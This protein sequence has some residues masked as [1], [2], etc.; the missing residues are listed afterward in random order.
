MVTQTRQAPQ[1]NNISVARY[2]LSDIIRE[3]V[4]YHPSVARSY[5]SY[6]RARSLAKAASGQWQPQV[7]LFGSH[8]FKNDFSLPANESNP[9]NETKNSYGLRV[10]QNLNYQNLKLTQKGARSE[11]EASKERLF[12]SQDQIGVE[13]ALSYVQIFRFYN[14][15][16]IGV[17]YLNLL[18]RI[19]GKVKARTKSGLTNALETKKVA[20]IE[21]RVIA[22]NEFNRRQYEIAQIF[23][24]NISGIENLNI[25]AL[26]DFNFRIPSLALSEE[27]LVEKAISTN[28]GLTAA[29]KDIEIAE[30]E[31][32]KEKLSRY[33]T[34]DLDADLTY[35]D[36][37]DASREGTFR[38]GSV[39]INMN[40]DIWT[41]RTKANKIAS[42]RWELEEDI[43]QYEVIK[44]QVINQVQ[45]SYTGFNVAISEYKHAEEARKKAIELLRLQEQDFS[46][47]STT[48]LLDLINTTQDWY[49]SASE[50]IDAYYELMSR[51][52]QIKR[53]TGE[54]LDNNI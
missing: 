32:R 19:E 42:S 51:Y 4:N 26:L 44:L 30:L 27:K 10:N 22:E 38:D 8:N 14:R 1:N 36:Y 40:Y 23:L 20:V 35:Q 9:G 47:G 7:S 48:S 16:E 49:R 33:P 45:E 39:R 28:R 43:N 34:F 53:Y 52:I 3:T 46:K 41:G 6:E 25:R 13:A 24:S 12:E 18:S 15:F 21:A 54:I 50:E 5:A 29:K 17:D 11:Q 37:T 2:S 31:W